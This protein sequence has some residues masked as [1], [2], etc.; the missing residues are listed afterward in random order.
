MDLTSG[1]RP[2]RRAFIRIGVDP[3]EI[4]ASNTGLRSGSDARSLRLD[5]DH[6]WDELANEVRCIPVSQCEN[7]NGQFIEAEE[8]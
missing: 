8:G 5:S 6:G 3:F 2:I 1:Q 4:D 7:Q